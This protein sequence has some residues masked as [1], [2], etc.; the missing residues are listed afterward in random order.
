[1]F[2][3]IIIIFI[4]VVGAVVITILKNKLDQ[5]EDNTKSIP[6]KIAESFPA[7]RKALLSPA[8]TSFYNVLRDIIPA[9]REI[10]CKCRLEDIMY[11]ENCEKKNSYRNQIKSRHVDFVIFNPQNG[12]TDFAI[13]LDDQSHQDKQNEDEFKNQIFKQIGM[14]LIRIPAKR[15]YDRNEIAKCITSSSTR[16]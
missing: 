12:Y 7:K 15:G 9:D 10:T 3:F 2:V 1:M 4:L 5:T 6:E 11:I 14:K 16:S 8:E 13:E